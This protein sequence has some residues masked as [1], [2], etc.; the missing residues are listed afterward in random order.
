MKDSP[1]LVVFLDQDEQFWVFWTE[2]WS[3][4]VDEHGR[5]IVYMLWVSK[6]TGRITCDC[7]GAWRH[8]KYGNVIGDSNPCR[9]IAALQARFKEIIRD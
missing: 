4:K 5:P 8:H 1:R 7:A 3:G 6:D 2:S 9:H